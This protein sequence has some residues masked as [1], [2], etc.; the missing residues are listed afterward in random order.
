MFGGLESLVMLAL[1][2]NENTVNGNKRVEVCRNCG[3]TFVTDDDSA[4]FCSY[5]CQRKSA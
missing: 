4:E 5:D 1:V 2:K 3:K